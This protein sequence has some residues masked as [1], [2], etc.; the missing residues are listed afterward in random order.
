MTDKTALRSWTRNYL[1]ELLHIPPEDIDLDQGLGELGLDS[2]DSIL[3]SGEM[4]QQFGIELEP[5]MFLEAD[6]LREM[7]DKISA[8]YSA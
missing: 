7:L 6:T 1:S 5:S 4:E 8:H 2:A 3:L